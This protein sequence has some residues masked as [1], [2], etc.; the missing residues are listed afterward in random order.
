MSR[1][2]FTIGR[3]WLANPALPV[4]IGQIRKAFRGCA[5]VLDVGCGKSSPLRFLSEVRLA[6]VDGFAP[7]LEEAKALGTHDEYVYGDV[8]KIDE[9]FRDKKFD[10][11]IALDLIEHLPKE[12]GWRLLQAM[13]KLATKRVVIFT[14]NGF[15]PQKSRN[16]D[17]Q[18]HLSGW[19]A[20]DLRPLGYEVFG[21]AGPKPWRGE[22]HVIR[23]RPRVLWALLSLAVDCTYTRSHPE[24]AAAILAVKKLA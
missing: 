15:L 24:G 19:T 13:E 5:S 8:R 14:P 23:Y 4:L 21:M 3:E 7:A 22:Y 9:L 12:D 6:G 10:G 18:E 20:E 17:L 2:S 16:G 1:R 11:C